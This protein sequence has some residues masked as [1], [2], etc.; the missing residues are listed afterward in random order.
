[1]CKD[2]F[3]ALTVYIQKMLHTLEQV[4]LEIHFEDDN[5]EGDEVSGNRD[6]LHAFIMLHFLSKEKCVNKAIYEPASI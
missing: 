2:K 1:M 4:W 5:E 6:S 3:A